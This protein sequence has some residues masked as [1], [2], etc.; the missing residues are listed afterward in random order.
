[1]FLKWSRRRALL[2]VIFLL[3]VVEGDVLKLVICPLKIF[4]TVSGNAGFIVF[5]VMFSETYYWP[6]EEEKLYCYDITVS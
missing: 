5:A 1:M 3:H 6:L 2:L 4:T